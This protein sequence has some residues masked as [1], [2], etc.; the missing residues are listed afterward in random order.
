MTISIH[1]PTKGATLLLPP[2]LLLQAFQS[3]L[4]RRERP[5]TSGNP[6]KLTNF[7]PRSHEGSDSWK[8]ISSGDPAISIHAPTKG[9]TETTLSTLR[10][11][12]ISIHAP[13]KGAT[14][15]RPVSRECQCNFN[16][17]SHEGSDCGLFFISSRSCSISIHAPTKGATI[18]PAALLLERQQ[19]QSTLPRRERRSDK[20]CTRGV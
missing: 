15:Y 18:F 7:N 12:V 11:S 1:A 2:A 9:A 13:T 19:F 3:T 16:P 17:R 20:D 8:L 4:P 10:L 14:R 5:F 6:F